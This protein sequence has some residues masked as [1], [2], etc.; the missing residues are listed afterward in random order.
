MIYIW[1]RRTTHWEDEKIFF[2][3]LKDDFRP[4][5]EAWNSVFK[6]PYNIFRHRLKQ[7]AQLNLSRVENA[8]CTTMDEIPNGSI[9]VPIDD[10]DWLSP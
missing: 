4:K 10:D 5:V 9:V 6:M 2:K 1:L 3:Q 8:L 7:I